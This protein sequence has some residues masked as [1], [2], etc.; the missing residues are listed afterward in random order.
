MTLEFKETCVAFGTHQTHCFVPKI[1]HLTF[2][3][4]LNLESLLTE[5]ASEC[6]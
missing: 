5:I 3:M 1:T 4:Q 6:F 2:L